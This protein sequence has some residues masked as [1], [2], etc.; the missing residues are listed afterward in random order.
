MQ[1]LREISPYL[2]SHELIKTCYQYAGLGRIYSTNHS[3]KSSRLGKNKSRNSSYMIRASG[4][5]LTCKISHI[6]GLKWTVLDCTGLYWALLGSTERQWSVLGSYG[7]YL[8]VTDSTGLFWSVLGCT[9][10]YWPILCCTGLYSALM[11]CNGL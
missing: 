6:T 4:A 8:V 7:L 11:D 1:L 5:F 2:Q 10:P 9:G 3:F